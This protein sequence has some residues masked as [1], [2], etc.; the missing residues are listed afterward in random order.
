MQLM[1]GFSIFW[2]GI[3][4]VESFPGEMIVAQVDQSFAY[5]YWYH[6]HILLLII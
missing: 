1:F 2:H 6:P 3:V 5:M 4:H